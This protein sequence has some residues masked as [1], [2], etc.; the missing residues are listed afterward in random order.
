YE[1][2][3]SEVGKYFQE[4]IALLNNIYDNHT[5]SRDK[6]EE[7]VLN[8]VRGLCREG[9]VMLILPFMEKIASNKHLNWQAGLN[10]LRLIKNYDSDFID[11]DTCLKVDQLLNV[12]T[13]DDL[14]GKFLD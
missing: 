11:D 7:I 2:T 9:L 13:K 10:S 4:I 6:I 1:P 8:R 3:Y 14:L 5:G 12:L